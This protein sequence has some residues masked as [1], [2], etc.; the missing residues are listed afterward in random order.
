MRDYY[1]PKRSYVGTYNDKEQ[2]HGLGIYDVRLLG[3]CAGTFFNNQVNGYAAKEWRHGESYV[4]QY[5]ND[6]KEGYGTQTWQT[7]A[8]FVG[9]FKNNR[10]E[11]YGIL[12]TVHDGIKFIGWVV[13]HE[14]IPQEWIC[15]KWYDKNNKPIKR[16]KYGL[17]AHGN[18]WNGAVDD[19]GRYHGKGSLV[20]PIGSVRTGTWEHGVLV[21]KYT[22]QEKDFIE[23]MEY[24]SDINMYYGRREHY[25]YNDW[26]YRYTGYYMSGRPHGPKG[27]F[28]YNTN[29]GDQKGNFVLGRREEHETYTSVAVDNWGKGKLTHAVGRRLRR[30]YNLLYDA[31]ILQFAKQWNQLNE[32][33]PPTIV[34]FGIGKG[35]HLNHWRSIFPD[36]TIIG[37]DLLSPDHIPTTD[38]EAQQVADLKYAQKHTDAILYFGKDCY[39]E[40]TIWEIVEEH[41]KWDFCVHDATHGETVWNRL[42]TAK[43]ALKWHGILITEELACDPDA[44]LETAIN[45]DQVALAKSA[46]WQVYNFCGIA[47]SYPY[48]SVA[49]IWTNAPF[50]QLSLGEYRC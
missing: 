35:Q 34:E 33:K 37:V 2:E 40:S 43:A 23:S 5:K 46:G 32:G 47:K 1:S 21:G 36:A 45:Y 26:Y 13:G 4:G 31:A 48:N 16:E 9:Q 12:T 15:G 30:S 42:E 24:F 7:G 18:R 25:I 22:Y 44:T 28:E 27:L 29:E 10:A 8:M 6:R 20:S 39:N 11:G 19:D 17:D 49:G 3:K 50:N 41:G 38:L 14:A